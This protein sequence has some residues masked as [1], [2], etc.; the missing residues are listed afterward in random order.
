M[1]SEVR[2]YSG[3]DQIECQRVSLRKAQGTVTQYLKSLPADASWKNVKAILRQVF[4]DSSS[5]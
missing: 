1:D 4:P 3:C 2:K 5:N